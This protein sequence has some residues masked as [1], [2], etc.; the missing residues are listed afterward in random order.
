MSEKFKAPRGT[1]DV[2]PEDA[3]VRRRIEE[4]SARV[5]ETAGY[6][7]IEV[8]IFEETDLFAR[9]VGES[10]DIVQKQMF[11]FED[12][13]GRS[14]TLRPEATASVCRA[15]LEH[16]MQKLAQPVKLWTDGAFFRHERPQAGRYR[17]FTQIDAEAIGSDSP[18]V[19]A[20]LIL[21]ANDI[22]TELGVEDVRLRLGSLGTPAARA[23]YLDELRAY[24]R[25]REDELSDEVRARID[26]NPLRAFDADHEG[27][28]HVMDEAP[29]L[30][31][32]LDPADGEHF[33]AVRELLDRNGITYEI[34][35][36]LVRGLDYYTRTVFEFECSRLGAQSGIGGGGRYDGLIE[37]LGGPPTPAC[38]WALGVD[39]IALALEAGSEAAAEPERE[40][41]FVVAEDD[42]REYALALVTELRRSGIAADLD[43]AG[44]AI[45]GQMKQADRLGAR[46]ALILG[47]HGKATLRDMTSGNEQEIDPANA[48]EMISA[49]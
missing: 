12:Q 48:T 4:V 31:E 18:L 32:R 37:L 20:E 23:S 38:G 22:L 3:P 27:T 46:Q 41:V 25:S 34:D 28:R 39:R 9:G 16:G 10:T 6:R 33:D 15:Y 35:P 2:L 5:L 19:D 30:L 26:V 17:Q 14:L 21:L 29:T 45:K 42:Q 49:S 24:L 44:R 11:S 43:L 40:G 13:G 1:F 47:P 7:R 8:P 36:T